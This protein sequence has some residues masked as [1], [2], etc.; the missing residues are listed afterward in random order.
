MVSRLF[1]ALV[2]F[3]PTFAWSRNILYSASIPRDEIELLNTDLVRPMDLVD[4]IPDFK[5]L[6]G[7]GDLSRQSLLGWITE[8]VGYL[9]AETEDINGLVSQKYEYQNP[10]ILPEFEIPK[11]LTEIPLRSS[12]D[13]LPS[14]PGV[15]M[16]NIGVHIYYRGKE[17][18]TLMD[19]A[20]QDSLSPSQKTL[21]AIKSPRVGILQIGKELFSRRIN[22][23]DERALSNSIF[24]LA[25]LFH[26]AHHSDGKA[27]SLGFFHALCPKGSDYNNINACDS[28]AN[29]PYHIEALFIRQAI[30]A[31]QLEKT[32]SDDEIER[33]A[34]I[35]V[36]LESRVLSD[37]IWDGTPEG[38]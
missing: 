7:V 28:A 26:E 15:V 9:V 29:G 23:G 18:H 31:C 10:G 32:C 3:V 5:E 13:H 19:Y 30:L 25:T 16:S 27:K 33:L 14:R 34:Y 12:P 24:R 22:E 11:G 2:L 35:G 17:K 38:I 20:F 4:D 6:L 36:D 1:L 37:A 21:L 8:R